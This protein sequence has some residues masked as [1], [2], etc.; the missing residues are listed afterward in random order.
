MRDVSDMIRFVD[1]KLK[2]TRSIVTRYVKEVPF[3]KNDAIQ[4][5]NLL[6]P[7]RQLQQVYGSFRSTTA[8]LV[9]PSLCYSFDLCK[10][11]GSL[12]TTQRVG[13]TNQFI[14]FSF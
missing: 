8:V 1:N 5:K 7:K 4:D 11:A 10:T 9:H 6:R 2:Q 12:L 3:A 13:R 14:F